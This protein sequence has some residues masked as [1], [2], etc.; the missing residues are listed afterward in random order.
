[1]KTVY[2]LLSAFYLDDWIRI[3]ESTYQINDFEY[4][5]NISTISID[6]KGGFKRP[7]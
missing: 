4:S 3:V 5:H 1:M 2:S 6:D 7:S